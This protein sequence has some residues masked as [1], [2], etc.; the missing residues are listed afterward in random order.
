[1]LG[2]VESVYPYIHTKALIEV[3]TNGSSIISIIK[4]IGIF[5]TISTEKLE[6]QP[7]DRRINKLAK[8]PKDL[9]R[10]VLKIVFRGI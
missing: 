2:V 5:Y 10:G 3:V 1:M 9:S 8:G 6:M 7:V 4:I